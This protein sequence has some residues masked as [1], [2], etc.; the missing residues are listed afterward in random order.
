MQQKL[1]EGSAALD[2]DQN[3]HSD[4]GWDAFSVW[5]T[6]VK[7]RVA[8]QGNPQ[9]DSGWDPYDV[10]RKRIRKNGVPTAV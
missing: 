3:E 4:S 10:W 1:T 2:L 8:S 6:R 7:R 5:E 9:A